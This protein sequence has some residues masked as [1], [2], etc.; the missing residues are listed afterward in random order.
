MNT[1]ANIPPNMLDIGIVNNMPDRALRATERQFAALINSAAGGVEV[2]LSF[3]ALPDVPRTDAGQRHIA[4]RYFS[5]GSLWDRH[6]D[7]LIVTGTEPRASNLADEPYW[8]SFAKLIDWAEH[9]THSTVWSCLAAHAA[10]LH[11]DGI[12]RHRLKE[13]R[14]GLFDC[15]RSSDHPLAAGVSQRLAMPHSR[16]NDL[17]EDELTA[18]GYSV[19]TRG[20]NAGVDAFFRQGE[21]LSVFF[22]GHPEYEANTLLLEYGRDIGRYLRG[23]NDTYPLLPRNY[24]DRD[25]EDRLAALQERAMS[26]RRESLFADFQ[27]ALTGNHLP[28]G[29]HSTAT[30]LYGNWLRYLCA[31]KE[32]RLNERIRIADRVYSHRHSAAGD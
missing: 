10:V 11:K 24:F 32:Q 7:G 22:Q 15:V 23:D 25:V 13:K 16:W 4:S 26:E 17:S 19:L 31:R 20:E 12:P 27:T 14:F 29:W 9:N 28:N 6:L 5:I 30:Q 3:Y 1:S 18:H 8:K 21:S 2:R